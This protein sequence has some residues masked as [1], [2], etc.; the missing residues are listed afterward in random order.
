MWSSIFASFYNLPPRIPAENIATTLS[1]SEQL[2]K[3]AD[4]LNCTSLLSASISTALQSHRHALY[5]VISRDPARF[6]LLSFS[7]QNSSIYTGS[8]IYIIGAYPCWPWPTKRSVLPAFIM[9]LVNTKAEELDKTCLEAERDLLTLT[10]T[11][12]T[13]PVQ[14]HVNSQFDTW[15]IVQTFRDTLAQQFHALDCDRKKP[16]KRGTLFRKIR[17]GG[18][19]YMPYEEMRRLMTRVMPGAVDSL[20]EDLGLLK[21]H[22]RGVME[23]VSRNEGMVDIKGVEVGW[24]MCARIERRDIPWMVEEGEICDDL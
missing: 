23:E 24:L 1:T 20:E 22:A 9:D 4:A 8:Q 7:L 2:L 13:G 10:I 5:N 14:A 11:V 17:K 15:F 6:L 12:P 16:L 3:V 21:E 19:E 18:V